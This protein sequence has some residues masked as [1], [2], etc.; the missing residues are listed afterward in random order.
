[1]QDN[2]VVPPGNYDLDAR[3]G[4]IKMQNVL[5][6]SYTVVEIS[7]PAGYSVDPTVYTLN[8]TSNQ[9][10]TFVSRD[11]PFTGIPAS[12]NTTL[13]IMIAIFGALICGFILWRSRRTQISHP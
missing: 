6:G 9:I 1:V 13:W 7:A 12:S 4:Y 2:V 8:V 11:R 10:A 3:N 5:T